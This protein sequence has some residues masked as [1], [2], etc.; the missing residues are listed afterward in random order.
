MIWANEHLETL[1]LFIVCAFLTA[2]TSAVVLAPRCVPS[3]SEIER[4]EAEKGR[5]SLNDYL[6]GGQFIVRFE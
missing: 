1:G 5:A 4:Q 6:R 3:Q 2:I